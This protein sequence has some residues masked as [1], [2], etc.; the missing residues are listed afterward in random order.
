M[1]AGIGQDD[2]QT[3]LAKIPA[4]KSI[5]ILDT[6][7]S[8]DAI[9]G[10][11]EQETAIDRLQHAPGRSVITAASD[12]AHEGYQGHG[13]LTGT[14]LEALTKTDGDGDDEVT[15]R[16]LADYV[17]RVVPKISQDVW[18]ERQ[19]PHIKIADDFLLGARVAAFAQTNAEAIIPKTPTHVLIRPER[20]REQ[21]ADA[22]P[23]NR[24]LAPACWCG[25]L[26]SWVNSQ[27]SLVM[28]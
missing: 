1:S 26:T 4:H 25:L 15:L 7:E 12:A 14:I 23:G 24:T 20:I 10:D 13:L 22:A 27:S 16:N 5:L 18:G 19:Q 9:R 11:I 17:Y 3:W 8:A 28:V 6:C 21:A 2:L